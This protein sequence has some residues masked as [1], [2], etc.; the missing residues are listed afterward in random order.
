MVESSLFKWGFE[1]V[2]REAKSLAIPS[3]KSP[4]IFSSVEEVYVPEITV[5]K[6]NGETPI[7]TLIYGDCINGLSKLHSN[8]VDTFIT[9][10]PYNL[11][12]MGKEWDKSGIAFK[13]EFWEECLRVA[14]PGATL[15][16]FGGTR[17]FHRIMVAIEDAGWVV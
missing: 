16:C 13:T 12:F 9:D 2:E 8:L 17:T 11:G 14:K 6:M 4:P 3:F 10:P 7:N 1:A 5:E 15:L